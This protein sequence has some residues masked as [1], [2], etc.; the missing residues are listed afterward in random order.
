MALRNN[1]HGF[2]S[3]VSIYPDRLDC[4][5]RLILKIIHVD[6]GMI[7]RVVVWAALAVSLASGSTAAVAAPDLTPESHFAAKLVV[8]LAKGAPDSC[9][10][11][12][13][14]WIAIE[15]NV[16]KDA[17]STVQ[18]FLRGM[19]DTRLPFYFHSPGG[20]LTQGIAIG[21]MLRARKAVA[22]VGQTI[23]DACPGRQFDDACLKIKIRGESEAH[24]VTRGAAC[25]SACGYLFL[26]ATTREV[27]LDAA[28]GVH[29]TRVI[30]HSVGHATAAQLAGA[31]QR[32]KRQADRDRDAF[33][34]AMGISHGLVDLIKTIKFEDGRPLTREELYEFGIDART[35][36]ETEW[37]L[38]TKSGALIR[39][40]AL[41]KNS[42]GPSFRKLEWWLVCAGKDRAR[43]M[44][45]RE[46]DQNAIGTTGVALVAGAATMPNFASRPV[47]IG[48]FE[49]WSAALSADDMKTLLTVPQ[50][51][52]GEAMATPDGRSTA[53]VLDIDTRGLA[54][55]WSQMAPSC[56]T[57]PA[58]AVRPMFPAPTAVPG[59]PPK[60]A[61]ANPAPAKP[62]PDV[63]AHPTA[64][65]RP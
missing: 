10:P 14:H 51:Q 3:K 41:A 48:A 23:V 45:L 29:E 65:P 55:A 39:K 22:R 6:E 37:S 56:A 27:P 1:D 38:E 42:D 49:L 43:L 57:A 46:F 61:L 63:V 18:R 33:V 16:D 24:L 36:V 21:H 11:G 28:A 59:W 26:G 25:H 19:T 32:L 47:R 5:L 34:A 8:Y 7:F 53:S 35:F 60:P 40:R 31:E 12:C 44:F 13:D 58:N 52:M 64:S 62:A 9:G 2:S 17:A 54:P 4:Y 30:L 15:G 50:L 20:A